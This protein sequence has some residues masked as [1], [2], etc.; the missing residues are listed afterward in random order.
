MGL[1]IA[2]IGTGRIGAA[3][4]FKLGFEQYVD[5]LVLVDVIPKLASMVKEDI[6][7]GLALHGISIDIFAYEDASKVREADMVIITAGA[8]RKPGISRRDLAEKNFKVVSRIVKALFPHNEDSW[9]FVITNPVDALS[10]LVSQLTKSEKVVGTG[11]C[12]E[13]ARLRAYLS[14]TLRVPMSS[15]DAYVGGEHGEQA[16]PLW[17]MVSVDGKAIENFLK[18]QDVANYKEEAEKYIKNISS[19][20]ISVQGATMWGSAGAFIEIIRGIALNTGRVMCFSMAHRFEEVPIPI[21]VT[22][23]AKI[24][25]KLGPTTWDILLEDEKR[26]IID[27]AKAI[28][29]TYNRGKRSLDL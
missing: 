19:E 28:Y 4:A 5:E 6:Y 18:R 2:I 22:I 20:I 13:S 8:T 11:T 23:P 14:R 25:K 17:S 27:A 12:L 26:A 7:H 24:G 15:V 3:L 1:R 29:E 9:F 10:T 16:V 21:H